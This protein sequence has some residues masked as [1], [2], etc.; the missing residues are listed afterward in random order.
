M[1]G[2]KK[3]IFAE[4]TQEKN[5]MCTRD[6]NCPTQGVHTSDDSLFNGNY[7][8]KKWNSDAVKPYHQEILNVGTNSKKGNGSNVQSRSVKRK[9]KTVKHNK[10]KLKK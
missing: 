4:G 9:A 6:G 7:S 2:K 3:V 5:A 1:T 10:R 8:V